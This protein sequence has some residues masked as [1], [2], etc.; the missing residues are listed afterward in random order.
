MTIAAQARYVFVVVS[1]L[2]LASL[3][4]SRV[5]LFQRELAQAQKDHEDDLFTHSTVCADNNIRAHMGR[6]AALCERVAVSIRTPPWQTALSA[7]FRQ[8]HLCGDAPCTQIVHDATSTASSLVFSLVLICISPWVFMQA[9]NAIFN[10][11]DHIRAR[12]AIQRLPIMDD[13][14]KKDL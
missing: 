8:T 5:M 1:S 2:W 13:D 11:V 7:V 4:S 12:R 6:N 10:R 9:F 3:C 14:I